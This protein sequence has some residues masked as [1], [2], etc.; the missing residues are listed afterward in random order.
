MAFLF[1]IALPR[2]STLALGLI[3]F[4]LKSQQE[5]CT[6]NALHSFVVTRDSQ[7]KSGGRKQQQKLLLSFPQQ[8]FK[9]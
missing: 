3:P 9:A 4:A 6:L 5:H 1:I 7:L 2:G 8:P